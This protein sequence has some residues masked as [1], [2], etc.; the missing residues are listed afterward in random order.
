[1][2]W[3]IRAGLPQL[4]G[5]RLSKSWGIQR[6]SEPAE[7]QIQILGCRGLKV[8]WA[9]GYLEPESHCLVQ[10]SLAGK[11]FVCIV[12]KRKTRGHNYKQS[13]RHEWLSGTA[14]QIVEDGFQISLKIERLCVCREGWKH[15]AGLCRGVRLSMAWCWRRLGNITYGCGCGELDFSSLSR[16]VAVL[17][18]LVGSSRGDEAGFCRGAW[19]KTKVGSKAGRSD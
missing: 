14:L 16:V 11:C 7:T 12:H 13:L 5:M 17:S 10:S 19:W 8:S 2:E 6:W 18:Y 3:V 4:F 1:M 15:R 9:L